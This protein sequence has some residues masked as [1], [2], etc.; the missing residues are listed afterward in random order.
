[1]LRFN[2]LKVTVPRF[3]VALYGLLLKIVVFILKVAFN[4]IFS[5]IILVFRGERECLTKSAY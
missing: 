3:T 1:M 2:I 4:N 5:F